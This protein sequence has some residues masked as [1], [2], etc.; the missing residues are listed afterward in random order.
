MM[1]KC[2][3]FVRTVHLFWVEKT[4]I[5]IQ[6]GPTP[7]DKIRGQQTEWSHRLIGKPTIYNH[8]L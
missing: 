8:S 1:N 6:E 5:Q 2:S 3:V 4:N 7:D